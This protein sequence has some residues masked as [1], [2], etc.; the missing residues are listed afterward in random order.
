VAN[1]R[2]EP[3]DGDLDDYKRVLLSGEE[4]AVSEV[5][6]PKRSKEDARRE[7][8]ER[9]LKLKPL[10]EKIDVEERHIASL[11]AQ[12]AKLDAAL[13]DPLLFLHD[14]AKGSIVSKKR[15]EAKR[16]LDA[17]ES[18]WVA[19]NEQYD[20]EMSEMEQIS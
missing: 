6:P 17:A 15:A 8:A 13:G 18:R 5:P 16:K 19:A 4:P 20:R 7:A 2:I 10:K 14:P 1:G 11:S 3:F 12:L 9:R